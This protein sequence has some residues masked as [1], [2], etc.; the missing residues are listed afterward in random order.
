MFCSL[1][2]FGVVNTDS[3]VTAL[4]ACK[5]SPFADHKVLVT[6]WKETSRVFELKPD[7][8][9]F[10]YWLTETRVKAFGVFVDSNYHKEE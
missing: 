8:N 6:G 9:L 1:A 3:A 2:Y 4:S 10:K 5:A 7:E